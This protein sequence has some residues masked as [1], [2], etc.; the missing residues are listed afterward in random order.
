MKEK[1]YGILMTIGATFWAGAF[2]AGKIGV[3]DTSPLLLTY[4]RFLVAILF[5]YPYLKFRKVD[6]RIE[7]K[8][9]LLMFT[10][11]LI[12]MT[13]YHMLFFSALKFT[14]ATKASM[15]AATNP[16]IT[17]VLASLFL[18]EKLTLKK[19]I[20]IGVALTGVLLTLGN[21]NLSVLWSGGFNLGDIIMLSAV[22]CWAFYG[23]IVRLNVKKYD[24]MIMTFYSFL[25]CLIILSPF[26][27]ME[28]MKTGMNVSKNSW[29]AIIYMGIFPTFIGYLIQQMTIKELGVSKMALFI[30]LVP[31]FSMIMAITILKEELFLLN[32]VSSAMILLSVYLFVTLKTE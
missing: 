19:I 27:T 4:F 10:L 17:A 7:G 31:V 18:N 26:F 16:L 11:G 5:M 28:V 6:L 29:I 30:N 20:L 8:D 23:I 24:P 22:T 21:W 12:G 25:T 3:G 32:L 14:T 13:G 1:K 9:W 15:L 2:I